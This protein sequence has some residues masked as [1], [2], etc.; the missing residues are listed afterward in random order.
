MSGANYISIIT[1]IQVQEGGTGQELGKSTKEN[2]GY[3][4]NARMTFCGYLWRGR[5]TA[6]KNWWLKK[7]PI[8]AT[9][10]ERILSLMAW[11]AAQVAERERIKGRVKEAA[12]S[13]WCIRNQVGDEPYGLYIGPPLNT[14]EQFVEKLMEE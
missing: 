4:T 12:E 6:F 14:L 10:D 11:H 9:T 7:A 3:A 5:M 8:P 13:L 2:F 1:D